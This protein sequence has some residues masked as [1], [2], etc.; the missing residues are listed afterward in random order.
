MRRV[1]GRAA[2]S[3]SGGKETA[4]YSFGGKY[5]RRCAACSGDGYAALLL[6]DYKSG[7]QAV[8]ATVSSA[9]S[10]IA[11]LEISSEALGHLRRRA[12]YRGAL[13]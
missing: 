10:E 11:R 12:I 13:Q 1:G 4:S 2:L 8:L 7:S 9:G 5:L 3:R 6:G